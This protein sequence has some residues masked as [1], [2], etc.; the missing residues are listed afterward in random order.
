MDIKV[1]AD[2]PAVQVPL[3]WRPIPPA[4]QGFSRQG[5]MVNQRGPSPGMNS[6][7]HGWVYE[8]KKFRRCV[9]NKHLFT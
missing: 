7:P 8:Y 3:L 5:L 4:P 6:V 9:N 2:S 1:G